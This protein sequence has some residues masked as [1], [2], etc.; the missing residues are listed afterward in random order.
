MNAKLVGLGVVV[1]MALWTSQSWAADDFNYL[2]NGGF[3]VESPD[4]VT[5]P[6]GWFPFSSKNILIELS[7]TAPKSGKN[8]VKMS[9]QQVPN[10]SM[11]IAQI[12]PVDAGVTY[13]FTVQLKNNS[14]NPLGN[15]ASGMIGIE[16]KSS[17]GKEISRTTS[18]EWDMSL[19]RTRWESI[20][21][22]EKAPRGA[23]TAA[24]TISLFDGD[25]G[26]AGSCFVDDARVEMKK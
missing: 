24:F 20:N 21:V 5:L 14:Q 7:Q 9:A 6:A 18:T 26:G 1:L 3:E 11:G 23:R 16:W 4:A 19:S 2:T 15:G 8:C 17:D 10:A 22:A 12:I 13:S 25:K